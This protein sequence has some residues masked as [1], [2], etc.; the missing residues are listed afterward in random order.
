MATQVID[1]TPE[2]EFILN[3]VPQDPNPTFTNHPA[4]A[5]ALHEVGLTTKACRLDDCDQFF[6]ELECVNGHK[7][8]RASHCGCNVCLDCALRHADSRLAQL[9]PYFPQ[10][11]T[12]FSRLSY[13]ELDIPCDLYDRSRVQ[14]LTTAATCT[15]LSKLNDGGAALRD[16]YAKVD[17]GITLFTFIA[18]FPSPGVLRL[19]FVLLTHDTDA[20]SFTDLKHAWPDAARVVVSSTHSTEIAKFI[21]FLF[22]PCIPKSPT[23]CAQMELALTYVRRLRTLGMLTLEL[24]STT[25]SEMIVEEGDSV[26][27]ISE[28]SDSK[29]PKKGKVCKKCGA[30]IVRSEMIRR[31]QLLQPPKIPHFVN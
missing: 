5:Q 14:L 23:L 19:R 10:L 25:T 22:R 17:T 31:D 20:P 27:N 28:E 21:K 26:T 18:G 15:L 12:T 13:V 7:T 30:P 6:N 29:E 2:Q 9:T 3:H 16:F 11:M 4:L 8:R 1:L 24:E